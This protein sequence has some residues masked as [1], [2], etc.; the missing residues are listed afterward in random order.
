MLLCFGDVPTSYASNVRFS[1]HT[2]MRDNR[3]SDRATQISAFHDDTTGRGDTWSPPCDIELLTA[4]VSVPR[5]AVAL[6]DH[7][8]PDA[9]ETMVDRIRDRL[10]PIDILR[11]NAM[12][13]PSKPS[14]DIGTEEIDSVFDVNFRGV[15]LTTQT[16]VP[17]M[18]ARDSS[19]V[20]P[21]EAM[22]SLGKS[23]HTH[24]Y[25]P[26]LGIEGQIRQ[27]ATE[28]GRRRNPD[29]RRLRRPHRR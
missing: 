14:L 20:D 21:I 1:H 26:K 10:G 11:N 2:A 3:K 5:A 7:V 22:V 9:F 25:G 16:V 19:V 8:D 4:E 18:K 15:F 13:R 24:S 23:G 12:Y 17:E 27:L 28:L 6:G 29:Q